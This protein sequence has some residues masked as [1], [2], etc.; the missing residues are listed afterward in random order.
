[1]KSSRAGVPSLRFFFK[2][3]VVFILVALSFHINSSYYIVVYDKIFS[4][5]FSK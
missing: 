3:Y 1:M 5:R 4:S 2:R